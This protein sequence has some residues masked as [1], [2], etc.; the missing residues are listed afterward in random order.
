MYRKESFDTLGF[1][2]CD[3]ERP[4]SIGEKP[5]SSE[6]VGSLQDQP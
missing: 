3:A 6:I 4:H 5:T 1:G 2:D